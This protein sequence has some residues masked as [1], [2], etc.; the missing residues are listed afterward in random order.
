MIVTLDR[1]WL[2]PL[3]GTPARAFEVN[4]PL[5]H[6]PTITTDRRPGAGGNV[7][8]VET[9]PGRMDDAK[10]VLFNC[11]NDE[12]AWIDD[13][14][15]AYLCYRDPAGLKLYGY[16]DTDGY[17]PRPMGD[18]WSISFTFHAITHS[19]DVTA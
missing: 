5:T 15:G 17:Y 11:T 12:H 19:E 14:L 3:D 7:Y 8:A 6:L 13:H 9:A 2:T 18:S 1:L 16:Y 4:D 10:V